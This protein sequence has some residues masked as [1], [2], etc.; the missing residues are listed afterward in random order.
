[1][2][3]SLGIID[4]RYIIK[5][6]INFYFPLCTVKFFPSSDGHK[7]NFKPLLQEYK[8]HSHLTEMIRNKR[9]KK[10]VMKVELF[11]SFNI[12]VV[13]HS[14]HAMTISVSQW[15]VVQKT[16]L[17]NT[18]QSLKTICRNKNTACSI[19]N[20]TFECLSRF[21]KLDLQITAGW[22]RKY[23][24][25][26]STEQTVSSGGGAGGYSSVPYSCKSAVRVH[27]S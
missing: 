4:H 2:A 9:P 22:R 8:S 12:I 7:W 23:Q 27:P 19:Y 16:C 24:Q 11:T 20:Q 18:T 3:G 26:L 17:Q 15:L 25:C 5:T 14:S 21:R 10:I 13:I 1:M 6:F